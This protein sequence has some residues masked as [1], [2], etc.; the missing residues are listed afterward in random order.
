MPFG[1][2]RQNRQ[3]GASPAP[4]ANGSRGDLPTF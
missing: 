2:E 1:D 3:P 4:Q